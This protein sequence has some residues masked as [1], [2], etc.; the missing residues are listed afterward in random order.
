M[1]SKASVYETT[2]FKCP[3]CIVTSDMVMRKAVIGYCFNC[4]KQVSYAGQ[5]CDSCSIKIKK[6]CSCGKSVLSGKEHIKEL[7]TFARHMA[8]RE[9]D[10]EGMNDE[11]KFLI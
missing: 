5:C 2:S 6:C 10:M 9:Y 11:K 3:L 7:E 4:W 1:G 8:M